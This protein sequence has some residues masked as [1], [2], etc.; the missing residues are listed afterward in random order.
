[1][2]WIAFGL[3]L[4]LVAHGT[5]LAQSTPGG[6]PPPEVQR[7]GVVVD[8]GQR[9]E[10]HERHFAAGQHDVGVVRVRGK[11]AQA[12]VERRRGRG[13]VD[14]DEVVSRKVGVKGDP[15]HPALALGIHRQ[16]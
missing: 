7:A 1:M 15:Q 5:A 2:R 10:V 8:R 6:A 12:V 16:A 11:A 3:A 9:V 4:A 14:V 13:V